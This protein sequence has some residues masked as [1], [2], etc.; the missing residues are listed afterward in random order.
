MCAIRISQED[1]VGAASGLQTAV[2]IQRH[3]SVA[4]ESI[5]AGRQPFD[6]LRAG[7]DP[8]SSHVIPAVIKK[9]VDA[10][11]EKK[12]TIEVWGTG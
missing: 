5:R 10:V 7:F 1:A 3:L 11:R 8:A 6:R 9:C 12:D 2:W 4:G